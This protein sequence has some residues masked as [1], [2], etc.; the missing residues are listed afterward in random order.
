MGDAKRYVLARRAEGSFMEEA[1]LIG[2][3]VKHSDYAALEQEL[4]RLQAKWTEEGNFMYGSVEHGTFYWTGRDA[5]DI[6]P[7]FDGGG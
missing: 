5:P 4:A 1:P 2:G 3:W 6:D 7:D